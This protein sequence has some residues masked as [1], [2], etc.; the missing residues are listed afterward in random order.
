MEWHGNVFR[1]HRFLIAYVCRRIWRGMLL[2]V[3]ASA[4]CFSLF[5]LAP[6]DFFSGLRLDPRVPQ[7]TVEALR[8]HYALNRPLYVRYFVWLG[9]VFRGEWGY[10][11]AYG[12][13]AG[14]LLWAR[15]RN[16]LLLTGTATLLAW[17]T[18]VPLGI[19]GASSPART[20]RALVAAL[21][22]LLMALPDLLLVLLLMLLAVRTGFLPLG[23]MTSVTVTRLTPWGTLTDVA[24][25]LVLP[26]AALTL[27]MLPP[28]IGHT[29]SAMSEVLSTSYIRAA[30]GHGIGGARLLFRHALPAAANSLISLFGLSLGALLSSS[31]LVEAAMGWPG[32]GQLLLQATLERDIYVVIGGV[33][34]SALFLVGGNFIADILHLAVDPRISRGRIS[35]ESP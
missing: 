32:L 5:Q 12:E 8:S 15:A 18:A 24:M 14:P 25:H 13:P 23:G 22:S 33:M 31:L 1:K 16:T 20:V 35:G 21:I 3:C 2:L 29:R 34:W 28:L 27:S 7:A 30:R 6:G 11:F 19:V 4:F 9:S 17:L 26:A 10:S